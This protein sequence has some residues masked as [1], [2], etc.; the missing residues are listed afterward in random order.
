M[1]S[2]PIKSIIIQKY[3]QN[4]VNKILVNPPY[5]VL[6]KEKLS[7]YI[8]KKND[9]TNHAAELKNAPGRICFVL[10][11]SLGKKRYIMIKTTINVKNARKKRIVAK[12]YMFILEDWFKAI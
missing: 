2:A 5:I 11:F 1:I 9:N 4:K 3:N 10:K 12:K 7:K 8:E 6:K